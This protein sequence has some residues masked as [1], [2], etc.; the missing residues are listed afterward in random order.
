MRKN[1]KYSVLLIISLSICN[2]LIL[3]C[4]TN[5][6]ILQ[7]PS[8]VTDIDGNVYNT[9]IIGNQAWTVENLNAIRFSNGDY[10][11]KIESYSVWLTLSTPA[12]CNYANDTLNAKIYGR[13]YNHFAVVDNRN[14]CPIGWHVATNVDW[15]TLGSFLGQ[16]PGGKMKE[17]G[18]EHWKSPNTGATNESGFSA[19]PGGM[20]NPHGGFWEKEYYS[21]WFSA[22]TDTNLCHST[23]VC[24][25]SDAIFYFGWDKGAG[26][27]VRCVMDEN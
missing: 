21:Q 10:I 16:A 3:G 15:Q 22:T 18:T 19:L 6:D 1:Y 24:Y 11:P 25:D 13:L 26:F 17:I 14:I 9:I 20:L 7:V 2:F 12:Y 23:A 5:E 8:T 27:S 4:K